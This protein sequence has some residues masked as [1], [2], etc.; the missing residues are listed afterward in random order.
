MSDQIGLPTKERER[1]SVN[2]FE[3]IK[4]DQN[5][6]ITYS[7]EKTCVAMLRDCLTESERLALGL[8][9]AGLHASAG[10]PVMSA[11]DGLP[12]EPSQ[13]YSARLPEQWEREAVAFQAYAFALL[14]K[15]KQLLLS[16]VCR[17]LCPQLDGPNISW[18][19]LARWQVDPEKQRKPEPSLNELKGAYRSLCK[20]LGRDLEIFVG[21]WRQKRRSNGDVQDRLDSEA[22]LHVT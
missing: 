19:A 17:S 21:A 22:L 5:N 2:G 16:G 12:A 11:Y 3:R 6:A 10:R 8:Y 1:H 4:K 14:P 7:V 13:N 18:Q 9:T 15:W 20:T